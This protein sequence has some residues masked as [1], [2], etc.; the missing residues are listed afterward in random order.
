M[1]KEHQRSTGVGPDSATPKHDR[2]LYVGNFPPNITQQRLVEMLN[3]AMLVLKG[4]IKEGLPV[5]S[6]WISQDAHYAFVEFRTMEECNNGFQLS[7]ISIFGHPL[8]IGRTKMGSMMGDSIIPQKST[9]QNSMSLCLEITNIP[10]FY[11]SQPDLLTKLLKMFGTYT[12][13]E[14]KSRPNPNPNL[15]I[16]SLTCFV[17][18]ECEEHVSKAL[19]GF[20][21]LLVK[22]SKLNCRRLNIGQATQVFSQIISGSRD[23]SKIITDGS[24]SAGCSERSRIVRLSNM[25]VLENMRGKQDYYDIEDDVYEECRRYG[26][27]RDITIPRPFH[28]Q[29]KRPPLHVQFQKYGTFLTNPGAG[30]VYVKFERSEM[31]R[32]CVEGMGQRLYNGREVIAS[33]YSEDKWDKRDLE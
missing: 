19:K 2:Q 15:P 11:E 18:Y 7:Q 6:A 22:D 5:V 32:K 26:R 4:N 3:L 30:K 12:Q 33:L 20:Q 24:A 17:E 23:D 29:Y 8:R 27:I 1:D 28:L 14:T 9:Q 21:D 13:F 31:A 25:M 10:T 16:I